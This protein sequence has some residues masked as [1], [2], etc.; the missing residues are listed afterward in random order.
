MIGKWVSGGQIS[1]SM[2]ISPTYSSMALYLQCELKKNHNLKSYSIKSKF[3]FI[4]STNIF[5]WVKEIPNQ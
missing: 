5:W 3:L 2:N 4:V 1:E